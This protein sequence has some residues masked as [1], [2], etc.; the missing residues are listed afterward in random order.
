LLLESQAE[1]GNPRTNDGQ[2]EHTG[3]NRVTVT[4]GDKASFDLPFSGKRQLLTS[5]FS[6][7]VPVAVHFTNVFCYFDPWDENVSR[8]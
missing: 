3:N 6:Y 4:I 5:R 1:A 2:G 8:P 7:F